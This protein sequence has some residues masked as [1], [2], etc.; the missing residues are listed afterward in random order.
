MCFQLKWNSSLFSRETEQVE[1][2]VLLQPTETEFYV[3]YYPQHEQPN[4]ANAT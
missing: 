3:I 4:Q 1:Q 2:L